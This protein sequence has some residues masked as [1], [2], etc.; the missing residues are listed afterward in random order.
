MRN[1]INYPPSDSTTYQFDLEDLRAALNGRAADLATYLIGNPNR[2]MSSRRDLRFG[3]HGSLSI[4][5]AG[6][7]IGSWFDHE[8]GEHGGMFDLVMREQGCSFVE[9][10]SFA[11]EY[12]GDAPLPARPKSTLLSLGDY[13]DVSARRNRHLA[14]KLFEQA[15]SIEHPLAQRYFIEQR[16]LVVPRNLNNGRVLRF[17]KRCPFGSDHHPCILALFT[18]ISDNQPK[19]VSRIALTQDG[20]KIDRKMLGPTAGAAIKLSPDSNIRTMLHVGEGVETCIAGMLAGFAPAWSLGSAGAIANLPVLRGIGK[21][22]IFG[23]VNDGGA[24]GKAA[25][26]CA[27]RW[28]EKSKAKIFVIDPVKGNDLNDA[29]LAA[30]SGRAR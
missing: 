8:T 12:L 2:R 3:K 30:N 7:K 25:Q 10:L 18:G 17:H 14:I 27:D 6:P 19:A 22:F 24:N 20:Q 5:I 4:V 9:A 26:S 23:E 29:W 21:L 1:G 16:G 28:R 15:G 13:D 11:R